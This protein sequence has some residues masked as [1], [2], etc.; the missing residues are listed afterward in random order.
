MEEKQK[1]DRD[2]RNSA[3][4]NRQRETS[5]EEEKKITS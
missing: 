5:K 1:T 3:Y 2:N 4:N